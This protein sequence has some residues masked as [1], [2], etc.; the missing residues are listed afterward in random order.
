[1][2]HRVVR[3]GVRCASAWLIG[4]LSKVPKGLPRYPRTAVWKIILTTAAV[5]VAWGPVGAGTSQAV[6]QG[7]LTLDHIA[8]ANVEA[9]ASAVAAHSW[10]G[11]RC[12]SRPESTL[13]TTPFARITKSRWSQ[14]LVARPCR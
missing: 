5:V 1:M 14:C 6:G 9:T 8:T 2:L 3:I 7:L 13:K 12:L 10:V 4:G 11:H